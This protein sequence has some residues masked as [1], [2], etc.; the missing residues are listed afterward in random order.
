M[1]QTFKSK[2]IDRYIELLIQESIA[3][4]RGL[5]NVAGYDLSIEKDT[6][7]FK[8]YCLNFS[9]EDI[10]A[11]FEGAVEAKFIRGTK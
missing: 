3:E 1:K 8:R 11:S 9:D 7:A 2:V 5:F 6:R 4:G 10:L